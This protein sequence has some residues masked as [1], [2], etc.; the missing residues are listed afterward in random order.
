MPFNAVSIS[1]TSAPPFPPVLFNRGYLSPWARGC[2]GTQIY[3]LSTLH[4]GGVLPKYLLFSALT[5]A[6]SRFIYI[7]PKSQVACY[8][9][10][11]RDALTEC[12]THL[13]VNLHTPGFQGTPLC[14]PSISNYCVLFRF[15]RRSLSNP[16]TRFYP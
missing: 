11:G 1:A 9:I 6:F 10:E 4:R 13:R 3:F 2:P 7:K 14:K 15:Y 8:R 5:F 16:V 12:G